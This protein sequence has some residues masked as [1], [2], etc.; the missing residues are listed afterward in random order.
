MSCE[1][2]QAY[3]CLEEDGDGK[4]ELCIKGQVEGRECGEQ[5]RSWEVNGERGRVKSQTNCHFIRD[6]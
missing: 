6:D 2:K 3:D 5:R 1:L 4:G